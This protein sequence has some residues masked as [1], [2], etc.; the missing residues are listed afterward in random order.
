MPV[1]N[2]IEVWESSY[3]GIRDQLR[4]ERGA[5]MRPRLGMRSYSD[6]QID[7][8][9]RTEASKRVE[10]AINRWNEEREEKAREGVL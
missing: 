10:Q 8:Y 5:G 7:S 9:S 6:G 4:Q 1:P 3:L 2:W